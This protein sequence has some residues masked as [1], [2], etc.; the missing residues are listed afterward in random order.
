LNNSRFQTA[1]QAGISAAEVPRLKLKWAFAFPDTYISNGQPTVVGGRLFVPSANRRL[2]SLD[3]KTGC[4]YWM[5]EPDA[6]VRASPT[7]TSITGQRARSVA[8]FGDRRGTAYAIDAETAELIWK[9]HVDETGQS[10]GIS[11][12]PAYYDGRLYVPFTAAVE[13][14]VDLKTVCCRS[15]GALAALDAATGRVLWKTYTI[16]EEPRIT[17]QN[18]AG[19]NSS[20]RATRIRSAVA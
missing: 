3:A 6:P 9:T 15:R 4:Q 1:A 13:G 8:F 5:F 20:P 14:S 11:A 7:V 18:K 10:A 12:A 2:Y 19:P 16:L 17:G